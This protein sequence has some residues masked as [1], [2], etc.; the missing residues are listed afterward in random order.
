MRECN[1]SKIH[2]SS[3]FLLSIRFIVMSDTL[4]LV[5]SL[6]CNTSLHFTKLHFTKLIDTSIQYTKISTTTVICIISSLLL[7][8][9]FKSVFLLIVCNHHLTI[10]NNILLWLLCSSQPAICYTLQLSASKTVQIS[11]FLRGVLKSLRSSGMLFGVGTDTLPR[12][13]GNQL[14]ADGARRP[15]VS[16]ASNKT[17]IV[18]LS[19]IR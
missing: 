2:I 3:N 15:T 7:K 16:T 1:N 12:N 6:H 14:P 4:L 13:V 19:S 9:R 8:S 10:T 17:C 5:P 11:S 18:S